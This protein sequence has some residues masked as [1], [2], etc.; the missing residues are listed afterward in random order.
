MKLPTIILIGSLAANAAV[1]G[2]FL[3]KA[4][5]DVSA[6]AG[7]SASTVSPS[8][9][10]AIELS[11]AASTPEAAEAAL[12]SKIGTE[13]QSGNLSTLVARLRA[14]GFS[15]S[16]IRSIVAAQVSEQF[17]ARRKALLASQPEIPFWKNQRGYFMDPKTMSALRELG[18]EQQAVLKSLLGADAITNSDEM[19]AYQRRQF[20]NLPRE[21][22]EQIQSIASDYSELTQE[23]Y[24][25]TNGLFLPEDREKLA[26]LEKE[27]LADLAKVLTPQELE[28][29]QLR[30]SSTASILRSQLT[31]FDATE[32]EFRALYRAASAVEAQFGPLGNVR[33]SEDMRK[34]QEAVLAQV[35]GSFTPQRL[36][37]LKQATNPEYQQIN[38]LVA[39]LELPAST[40][41]QVVSMQKDIQQRVSKLQ[42]DRSLPPEER[43]RQLN[44]LNQEATAKLTATLGAR[45]FEAYKQNG[46]FWLQRLQSRPAQGAPGGN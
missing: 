10:D 43:T 41:E 36:A 11:K 29:Y 46:G 7:N 6:S 2:F 1:L 25:K 33:T 18:K 3:V 27:K 32:D 40:S 44:A 21:K 26:F 34:R 24:A 28:D 15:T 14:A 12:L 35:Q 45:G 13:L 23:I 37:E 5:A 38:R 4:P 39:R 19:Q 17:A 8:E 16:V 22:V 9:K 31:T 42:S 20:G 30:N